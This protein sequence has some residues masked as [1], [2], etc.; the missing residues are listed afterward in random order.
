MSG[1]LRFDSKREMDMMAAILIGKGKTITPRDKMPN[2]TFCFRAEPPVRWSSENNYHQK[3]AEYD[4]AVNAVLGLKAD[5]SMLTPRQLQ[6]KANSY[7]MCNCAYPV[8]RI[9][10][11]DKCFKC[12]NGI[13]D[14]GSRHP[15]KDELRAYLIGRFEAE[16]DDASQ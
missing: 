10:A 12:G 15:N 4:A 8:I 9:M 7:W 3:I 5:P 6:D 11:H 13:R 2:G 16:G 14:S 1:I